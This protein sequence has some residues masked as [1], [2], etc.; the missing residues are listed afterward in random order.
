MEEMQLPASF[1]TSEMEA[2][3]SSKTLVYVNKLQ[4]VTFQKAA[5]SIITVMGTLNLVL[6]I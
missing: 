1:L 2:E 4:A 6:V 3:T 5:F